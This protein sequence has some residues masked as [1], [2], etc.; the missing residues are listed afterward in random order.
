MLFEQRAAEAFSGAGPKTRSAFGLVRSSVARLVAT[1]A[2]LER[3]DW[4]TT[5]A[6]AARDA[7]TETADVPTLLLLHCE[8][9]L[10]VAADIEAEQTAATSFAKAFAA[11]VEDVEQAFSIAVRTGQ[12]RGA[13]R[14]LQSIRA[15]WDGALSAP[16]DVDA[17]VTQ[18][19]TQAASPLRISDCDR[20]QLLALATR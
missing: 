16:D 14:K 18:I 11:E 6:N 8:S 1:V 3:S 2:A 12:Y 19:A 5:V 7:V 13:A 9:L 4:K 17:I 20:H 10:L 15:R